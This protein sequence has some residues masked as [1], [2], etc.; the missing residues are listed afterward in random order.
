[1]NGL[2][3]GLALVAA[4]NPPRTRTGLPETT[5]GR[6]RLPV[7]LL[8]SGIALAVVA[9]LAWWSGPLLDALDVSPE[10]FRIAAG[11][12]AGI[13]GLRSIIRTSPGAEPELPGL[14]SAV[15]P[16]AFPRLVAPEV[17]ALAI[18]A[19][20]EDGV[21]GTVAAAAVAFA[22][23]AALGPLRRGAV[24]DGALRWAGAVLGMV[25]VVIGAVLMIDGVR[26]V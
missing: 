3:L 18:T 13:A 23:L 22:A 26:E 9:G 5:T 7:L 21:T 6:A 17:V 24:T 1:M 14:R 15:W 16:V 20:S 11:L 10:T 4:V 12:V 19:G 2:L 25:L 8:G